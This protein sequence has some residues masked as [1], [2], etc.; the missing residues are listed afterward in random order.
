M[1]I[2][3]RGAISNPEGRFEKEQREAFDDGW[4]HEEEI[5]PSLETLTIARTG[6]ISHHSQ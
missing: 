5:I 1:N 6:K 3:N 2:K 4:N